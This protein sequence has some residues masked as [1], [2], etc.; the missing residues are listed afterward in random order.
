MEYDARA[1][2]YYKV[3]EGEEEDAGSTEGRGVSQQPFVEG[4]SFP[5]SNNDNSGW[6]PY[7]FSTVHGQKHSGQG[8]QVTVGQPVRRR[9]GPEAAQ[10]ACPRPLSR[11]EADQTQEALRAIRG[12]SP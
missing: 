1:G 9:S 7:D 10:A 3:H 12:R 5:C 2:V 6:I 4:H 11:Q 8:N